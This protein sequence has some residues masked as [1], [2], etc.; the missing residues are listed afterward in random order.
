MELI[1]SPWIFSSHGCWRF[2]ALIK[3]LLKGWSPHVREFKTVL[4]PGFHVV[5]SRFQV[6]DSS[7]CQWNLDSRFHSVVRIQRAIL[8]IPKP[9]IPDSTSKNFPDS[10][11]Q[12]PLHLGVTINFQGR[13]QEF[14]IGGWRGVGSKLW[15]RKDSLSF[16]VANYRIYS[17]NHPGRLLNV[18]T[19]RVGAYSRWALINFFCL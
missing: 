10:G 7:L 12:I 4:D 2:D 5:V 6:L 11:I 3:V 14:L 16:F 1:D 17:I 18:W 8:P 9:R 15:F 13:I 19:V